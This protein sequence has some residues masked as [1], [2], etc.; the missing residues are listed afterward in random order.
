MFFHK[1]K[2]DSCTHFVDLGES[3]SF[4]YEDCRLSKLCGCWVGCL[5]VRIFLL[6]FYVGPRLFYCMGTTFQGW[7]S[8]PME[9]MFMCLCF[10]IQF[11]CVF[12]TCV[13]MQRQP[14]IQQ[15]NLPLIYHCSQTPKANS[16]ALLKHNQICYHT[17]QTIAKYA[18]LNLQTIAKYVIIG[19]Y[20][21]FDSI[22][23]NHIQPII[24]P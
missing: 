10:Q 1:S 12:L 3:Y 7:G 11:M 13:K 16:T 23:N 6:D 24:S 19:K 14:H 4:G 21:S 8:I 18:A 17:P 5:K 15:T 20:Q 2:Y 9:E 22:K